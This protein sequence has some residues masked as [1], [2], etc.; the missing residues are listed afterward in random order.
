LERPFITANFQIWGEALLQKWNVLLIEL[1]LQG[2]GGGGNHDPASTTDGRNQV[3][4]GFTGAGSGFHHG[5]M[6]FLEG[7]VH[8]FGHF[9][10]AGAMLIAADH[11]ALEET[12]GAEDIAH[13]R[14]R[15]R[16]GLVVEWL[17]LRRRLRFRRLSFDAR[18]VF[19]VY[20]YSGEGSSR[21]GVGSWFKSASAAGLG[22]RRANYRAPL[23]SHLRIVNKRNSY[24]NIRSG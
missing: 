14:R 19:H 9:Q 5:V 18:T 3:R 12:T 22:L 20:R 10:L 1:L 17:G 7:I 13:G 8:H 16:G 11:A 2:L 23:R 24:L 4:Q 15:L 21:T 6:M